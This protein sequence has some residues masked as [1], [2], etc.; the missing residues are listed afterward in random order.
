MFLKPPAGQYHTPPPGQTSWKPL[1]GLSKSS[2]NKAKTSSG[3]MVIFR[4]S[5][6]DLPTAGPSLLQE[7]K[8]GGFQ[9]G[10]EEIQA[11]Q[12]NFLFFHLPHPFRIVP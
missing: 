3:T 8:K 1:S 11:G 10:P 7:F 4:Y 9:G 5:C 12:A 2:G 6:P